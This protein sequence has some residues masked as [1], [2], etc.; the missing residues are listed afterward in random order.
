MTSIS[1]IQRIPCVFNLHLHHQLWF[2]FYIILYNFH[3]KSNQTAWWNP[4]FP[5]QD[6]WNKVVLQSSGSIDKPDTIVWQ[7]LIAL[8]IA[9]L[10]VWAM[11]IRGINIS[12]KLAYFT[13]LFP[14]VILLILGIRGI[15]FNCIEYII[16]ISFLFF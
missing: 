5:S 15:F 6:Y 16:D 13:S 7:L 2:S 3:S 1:L 14:Y 4:T 11:V 10:I 8:F 12:G 9:W